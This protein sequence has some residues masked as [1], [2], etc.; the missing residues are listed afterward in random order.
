MFSRYITF[1]SITKSVHDIATVKALD[2]VTAYPPTYVETEDDNHRR[3]NVLG[4][5]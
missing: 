5:F 4:A 1:Q 3:A 2:N